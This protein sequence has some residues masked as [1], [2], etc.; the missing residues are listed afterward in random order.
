MGSTIYFTSGTAI[1]QVLPHR[2]LRPG[3]D[4]LA[5]AK[6]QNKQLAMAAC[7][8][9]QHQRLRDKSTRNYLIIVRL[10][11]EDGMDGIDLRVTLRRT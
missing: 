9:V 4:D 2:C 6:V 10:I 11:S 8:T 3:T 7:P 1:I 5:W